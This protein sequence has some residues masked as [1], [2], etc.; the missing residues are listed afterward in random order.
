[1]AKSDT[2]KTRVY[3]KPLF[4]Y[5]LIFLVISTLAVSAVSLFYT[6]ELKKA[7]VPKNINV[8]DFLS[9]L[10]SHTEMKSYAGVNPLNIVQINSNNFANLQSQISGLYPSYVGSFIVQYSD[11]IVVYDYDNN[12]IKGNMNLQP[13][14]P[15]DMLAKLN[16]HSELKGLEKQQPVG[17]Q[18]DEA[19]LKT[20]KEQ[21][22]TV[23]K[24]A[25]TG[26]FLLRY[27]TKLII[28]DYKQDKIV[29]SVNLTQ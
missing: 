28:Y 23:Y 5:F 25:K 17:G 20:L 12:K 15:T 24:N 3:E 1:M 29:N 6:Y 22:P 2:E 7:L 11:R 4:Q 13:Q 10:T 26:D 27:Q 8:K 9:K 19:S 21:F 18:L 16:K 14:L